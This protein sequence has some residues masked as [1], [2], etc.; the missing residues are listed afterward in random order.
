MQNLDLYLKSAVVRRRFSDCFKAT[1]SFAPAG[2]KA[3]RIIFAGGVYVG[4]N[5]AHGAEL[6]ETPRAQA[7]RSAIGSV[8]L[9]Q[10]EAS[11]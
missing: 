5:T 4:K 8:E 11:K 1:Q 10:S 6:S 9:M 7:L 3:I 2:A